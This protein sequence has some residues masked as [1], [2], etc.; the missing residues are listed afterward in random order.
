MKTS[1][2]LSTGTVDTTVSDYLVTAD[3]V[4]AVPRLIFDWNLNRHTTPSADNTPAED[5]DGFDI[6]S[7]PIESIYNPRRPTKGVA[8]ALINQGVASA[9]YSNPNDIKFYV[10]DQDD[11]YKY[12]VSPYATNG[13]GN[14]PLH[15]DSKTTARPRVTY[16]SPLQVN[17]I[18]VKFET[19]WA[20]PDDY[21]IQIKT[22]TGGAYS[23]IGGTSPTIDS[24]GVATLY[25]N[26][27]SWGTTR[28]ST[29]VSTA[30][31]GI[32]LEVRSM[33]G[34]TDREGN[35]TTYVKRSYDTSSPSTLG[36]LTTHTTDG[37]NSSL[38]LIAIEPHLEVDFS[39][40]LIGEQ[41]T[42]DYST[43]SQLYPLGTL[44]AND[45][46]LTLA[47]DDRLLDQKNLSS[48]YYALVRQN[49]NVNLEYIFTIDDV[50]HSVQQ[51]NMYT[52]IW[53]PQSDGTM[54]VP[55][56]DYS[57]Y[58]D[59]DKPRS[60]MWENK[61]VTEIVWRICDS[62]G[63][64]DYDIQVEDVTTDHTIPVFW[65]D[66]TKTVWELFNELSEASQTAIYFD[67]RGRL[68]VRLRD[69][70]FNASA[71]PTIHL[72]GEDQGSSLANIISLEDAEEL[73]ANK[74][75][76]TYRA[77]DWKVGTTGLP[78]LDYVWQPDGDLVV[79]SS[80]LK[81]N[82]DDTSDKLWL[83]QKVVVVWPYTSKVQID[84]EILQYDGKEYIYWTGDGTVRNTVVV[85]SQDDIKKY[86]K[87]S[88]NTVNKNV[89]S[90]ALMLTERG[91]WNSDERDHNVDADN[92]S[93]Q[94]FVYQNGNLHSGSGARGFK[95]NR[96]SS[97]VTLDTPSNMKDAKDLLLAYRGSTAQTG[98]HLY[99]TRFQ[100]DQHGGPTQR[101]GI[102]VQLNGSNFNGY[103]IEVT[104]SSKIPNKKY[105][106][107]SEVQVWTR[108]GGD[109]KKL[110]QG[111]HTSIRAPRWYDLD[112]YVKQGSPDTIDVFLNGQLVSSAS[113]SGGD[114]QADSARVG[115][116]ARGK[117]KIHFEYFYAIARST[118][119]PLDGY[120]FWDLKNGAMR[121]A[122]WELEQ[123]W[124]K[125]T[126]STKRPRRKSTKNK[127][128]YSGYLFDEFGPYVH[129]VRE[130]DVK[131]DPAPVQY[132]FLF[133]TNTWEA[134]P[135]EYYSDAFS[136]H[137]VI[138]NI[139]RTN[140]ILQGDD[141]LL[142]GSGDA[143]SQVCTVLGRDLIV[144]EDQ[145]VTS[146]NDEA[147][148]I[149]GE[150]ESEM[151][152]DWIQTETMAQ[153]LCDWMK[154][155]W[156][157]G[158]DQI[159]VEVFGNPCYELGEVAD[160]Y[161]PSENMSPSTHKYFVVGLNTGFSNGVTTSMTLRRVA[162]S[163]DLI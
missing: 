14:F 34:G 139:S 85:K 43:T 30:V 69:A 104:P 71:S 36:T 97:T 51:F 2:N 105:K 107:T 94:Q 7:F 133:S 48:P 55:L 118:P 4:V 64:V 78:A 15:T 40:R 155:H 114:K 66:G 52:G 147:I 58:F 18:V 116:Y 151:S 54:Q 9:K 86:D 119:E 88:N 63:F 60:F 125:H 96:A 146:Q 33:G 76:V 135:V 92:W 126:K 56:T 144:Q 136:A 13:S 145:T 79:R 137:F 68:Q 74:I 99:G 161:W 149:D 117:S 62:V 42:F 57:K 17:K 65:S 53:A 25:Y 37:S 1:T 108:N 127:A 27:S 22:T 110:D 162:Q 160:V 6:D 81:K 5:T 11:I 123:V 113:A 122:S 16:P 106:H 32:Q 26:G 46:T 163:V 124:Q 158:V 3:N 23:N 12:W 70:A 10:G 21:N 143:V 45:S 31:A 148:R 159:E 132:S 73:Q 142:F 59:E 24:H 77:T 154:D 95:F 91:V 130:F 19:S 153:A 38:S 47:N 87:L 75:T 39:D 138:A 83:D 112:V 29:L 82:I 44:T 84:G 111:K 67:A 141:T 49:A 129:E 90:G 140:A 20:T 35:P 109:W 131:F 72:L 103:Y 41:N 8:K 120:G 50:E 89:L 150:V 115:M 134:A 28:P 157:I 80:Q 100:F 128:K 93:T 156:S 121:G 98:Y 102:A 61:S 101:A 152:S